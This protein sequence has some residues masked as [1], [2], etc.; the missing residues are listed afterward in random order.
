MEHLIKSR[1]L[2]YTI[3][4]AHAT[5]SVRRSQAMLPAPSVVEPPS[6]DVRTNASHGDN[7]RAP[8]TLAMSDGESE[9]GEP[10]RIV[11]KSNVHTHRS[12]M[13]LAAPLAV[14]RHSLA[15]N[16]NAGG[17]GPGS[18][19]NIASVSIADLVRRQAEMQVYGASEAV[20]TSR[21]NIIKYSQVALAK[22]EAEAHAVAV[23]A[24]RVT[25]L[26]DDDVVDMPRGRTQKRNTSM[27]IG[28]TR[29]RP[30]S[31]IPSELPMGAEKKRPSMYTNMVAKD[32]TTTVGTSHTSLALPDGKPHSPAVRTVELRNLMRT[33][34]A[35]SQGE[36]TAMQNVQKNVKFEM[37]VEN[38]AQAGADGV[39]SGVDASS[40]GEAK[41]AAAAAAV[42][43]RMR[44]RR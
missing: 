9:S 15:V 23:E 37:N 7:P 17:S 4:S 2:N 43:G 39:Q 18:T 1:R 26:Q 11:A 44:E 14:S 10:P 16:N 12:N 42:K 21:R 24:E 20:A 19:S 36:E 6:S 3:A 41:P 32:I 22:A 25:D 5:A 40:A 38:A 29:G 28:T 34:I 27:A 33:L 30:A 31:A 8:P 35:K 13:S